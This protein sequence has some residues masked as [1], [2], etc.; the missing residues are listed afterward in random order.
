MGGTDLV[1]WLQS[2]TGSTHFHK[3]SL[4]YAHFLAC[5]LTQRVC[6]LL[7]LTSTLEAGK[8]SKDTIWDS[9]PCRSDL[10][11]SPHLFTLIL[12]LPDTVWE[13]VIFKLFAGWRNGS[14]AD[15]S[16]WVT[17]SNECPTQSQRQRRRGSYTTKSNSSDHCRGDKKTGSEA[18]N[19]HKQRRFE[20]WQTET[21][22]LKTQRYE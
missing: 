14:H 3:N 7:K 6:R 20:S 2:A 17:S 5:Q 11:T 1:N 9:E 21:A 15:F 19:N 22:V 12:S 8:L 10:D 13:C 16:Q 4:N 18:R